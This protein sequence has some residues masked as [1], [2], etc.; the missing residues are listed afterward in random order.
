LPPPAA[1]AEVPTNE[2][3]SGSS[4]EKGMSEGELK[5]LLEVEEEE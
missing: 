3:G 2:M 5:Q 4:W 1:A